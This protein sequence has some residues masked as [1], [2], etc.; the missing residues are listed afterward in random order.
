VEQEVS[1]ENTIGA[2][3]DIAFLSQEEEEKASK[4]G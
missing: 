1:W 3:N 4:K 2:M